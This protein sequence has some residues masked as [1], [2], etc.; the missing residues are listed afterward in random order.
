MNVMSS[1]ERHISIRLPEQELKVLEKYCEDTKRTK[2]E[3]IRT[4]IRS[5]K[6]KVHSK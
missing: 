2:T 6:K 5:L 4:F 3:V 1:T